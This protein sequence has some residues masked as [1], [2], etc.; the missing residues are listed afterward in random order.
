METDQRQED[1]DDHVDE[2]QERENHDSSD[3]DQP[4]G[5]AGDEDP[6]LVA[7]LQGGKQLRTRRLV[8]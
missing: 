7:Q 4:Q 3:L 5:G 2:L 1:P 6:G 8:L